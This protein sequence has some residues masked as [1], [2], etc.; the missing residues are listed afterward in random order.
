MTHHFM[1]C[2]TKE[3]WHAVGGRTQSDP[4]TVHILGGLDKAVFGKRFSE[5]TAVL[6]G[7]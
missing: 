3:R 6:R 1:C 7:I 4:S 2:L 5:S